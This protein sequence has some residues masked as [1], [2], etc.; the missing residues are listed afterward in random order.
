MF[1]AIVND[2]MKIANIAYKIIRKY[3]LVVQT[4][5]I[6]KGQTGEFGEVSAVD[7]IHM[8]K[9]NRNHK[10]FLLS[11]QFRKGKYL[12]LC[13]HV[14]LVEE[15]GWVVWDEQIPSFICT[16][17]ITGIIYLPFKCT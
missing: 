8:K 15:W 7:P 4:I 17:L 13:V 14:C 10:D 5:F 16:L 12:L 2:E 1:A 3:M 9:K 6:I 11:C